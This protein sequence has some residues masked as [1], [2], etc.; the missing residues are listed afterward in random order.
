MYL[1]IENIDH[2]KTKAKSPQTNG[3]CE[4]FHRTMLEEFYQTAFRKNLYESLEA[5]QADADAWIGFYNEE[6]CHSGRY[7]F[8]KTPMQ[9]F[10]D[11]KQLA[12]DKML[13]NK[14]D[15]QATARAV[16]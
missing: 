15:P 4:R 5:L 11:A 2:T 9:T 7:C 1:A 6:R 3:I 10:L 12:H 13:D 14:R 16:V 8:G